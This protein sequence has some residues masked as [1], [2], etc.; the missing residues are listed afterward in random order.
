MKKR[1]VKSV[2][3]KSVFL[4]LLFALPLLCGCFS[5]TEPETGQGT[6]T[7]QTVSGYAQSIQALEKQLEAFRTTQQEQ[8]DAY[9][10]RLAE[11]ERALAASEN[12]SRT[13]VA[14][15]DF[16]YEI[17]D[18]GILLTG[19]KGSG[20]SLEIP[21]FLDGKPVIAVGDGAFRDSDLERVTVPEG[22][23]SIGWFAFSGCYKL[24]SVSLPASVTAIGYGAFEHCAVSIRITCPAGSYAARY[25]TSYGYQTVSQ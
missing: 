25:A 19:W 17:T 13:E 24:S 11:L 5:T 7:P 15:N 6:A 3:V 16:T 23:V 21:A 4:P 20:T 12:Q 22:V 14:S 2:T 18:S 1:T 9:E 10:A 8:N